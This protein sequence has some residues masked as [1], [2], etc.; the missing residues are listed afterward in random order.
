MYDAYGDDGIE[1]LIPEGEVKVVTHH[2]FTAS[3]PG[4][5]DQRCTVVTAQGM[6]LTVHFQILSSPTTYVGDETAWLLLLEEL[7][8][9]GPGFALQVAEVGRGALVHIMHVLLLQL[10]GCMVHPES[11]CDYR[12]L[13]L[14]FLIHGSFHPQRVTVVA[15]NFLS[16]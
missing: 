2:D 12:K 7:A 5:L 15:H 6:Y 10:G 1:A 8:D 14:V 3:A 9:A 11:S 13:L 4:N 16:V